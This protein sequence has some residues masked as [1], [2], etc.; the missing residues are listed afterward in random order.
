[1]ASALRGQRKTEHGVEPVAD[2]LARR[3]HRK[4]AAQISVG[5]LVVAAVATAGLIAV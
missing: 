5:A 3:L 4:V 2:P 1:V